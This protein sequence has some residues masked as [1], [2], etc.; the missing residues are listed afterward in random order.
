MYGMNQ[1]TSQHFLELA[2][3]HDFGAFV[4]ERGVIHFAR[5]DGSGETYDFH[6]EAVIYLHASDEQLENMKAY[7]AEHRPRASGGP[8]APGT[9]EIGDG[10]S[11]L[12]IHGAI[13]APQYPG[14]SMYGTTL[15]DL[16]D[17]RTET[18]DDDP[19]E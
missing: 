8:V 17:P 2:R 14:Q 18:P 3:S 4:N 5:I 1:L 10:P 6:V 12:I 16:I 13:L 9:Y 11:P 15:N 19:T 7:I